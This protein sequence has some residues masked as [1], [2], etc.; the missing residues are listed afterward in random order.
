MRKS[1]NHVGDR[2]TG[3]PVEEGSNSKVNGMM[4]SGGAVK[5]VKLSAIAL[6]AL[7][8]FSAAISLSSKPASADVATKII[9]G[10]VYDSSGDPQPGAQVSV[11][12]YNGL[13]WVNT[14]T[15]TTDGAG[16]YTITIAPGDWNVG[17]R[18]VVDATYNSDQVSETVIADASFGQT[19]NLQ[20][21]LGIPQF[22][23]LVGL[24]AAGAVV[25]G[26]AVVF[27]R[28]KR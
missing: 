17:Y 9:D 4:F 1:I 2:H 24:F 11:S 28:K 18:I 22:G 5:G 19:V 12:T 3:P 15:T 21:S 14:Q 20:F 16:F 13:T 7:F 26:V 8:A 23:T 25:A 27:L 10:H 6:V